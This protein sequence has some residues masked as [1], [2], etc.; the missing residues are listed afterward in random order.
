M[1][2]SKLYTLLSIIKNNGDVRRLK[3][4]GLDYIEIAE[5]TNEIISNNLAIYN[6]DSIELTEK[7]NKL[8][9]ELEEN[10]KIKNKRN[11]IDKENKSKIPKLD[12][13]FIFLPA[14]DELDF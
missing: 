14:Q 1:D 5:L 9:I 2:Y 3:R 13:N 4:A 8:L 12:K 6:N 10:F 11:W 7:G